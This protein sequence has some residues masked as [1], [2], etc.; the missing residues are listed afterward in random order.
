MS[1]MVTRR[2]QEG[3]CPGCGR[4][5]DT[6]SVYCSECLVKVRGAHDCLIATRRAAGDC[7]EC[8]APA[9][10][11]GNYSLCVKCWFK[12]MSKEHKGT[13]RR[14]ETLQQIYECRQGRCRY[15]GEVL[16]PGKTTSLDHI[17]PTSRGGSDEEGNLEWVTKRINSMK[18][19]LTHDEFIAIYRQV[20]TAIWAGTQ[21]SGKV[22]H[23]RAVSTN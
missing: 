9:V 16:V 8:G 18:G 14:W 17:I 1:A 20:S 6:D 10:T 11:R 21:P 13:K 7:P 15:T 5:S 23:E 3:F 2:R 22:P 19:D 12:K 4:S